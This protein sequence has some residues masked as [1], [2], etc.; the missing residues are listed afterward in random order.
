MAQNSKIEWTD[1]TWNPWMGCTKVS[2]GCKHCYAMTMMDHRYGKVKW[3]PQGERI[4]TAKAYWK[5]PLKWNET[6]FVQCEVCGLRQVFDQHGRCPGCQHPMVA[7]MQRVRQRVF[8]ASLADVFE[9]KADQ[10]EEMN[11]WRADLFTMIEQTPNLD[12][13]LLTK[14]PENVRAMCPSLPE[15]VWIG[16]SV[17][18][19]RMAEERIPALV[20]IPAKIHFLSVEPMLE[21]IDLDLRGKHY[22]ID[23]PTYSEDVSWVICGGESGPDAR[24][25]N[26]EWARSLRDQCQ[27]AGVPFFFKQWGEWAPRSHVQVL[28]LNGKEKTFKKKP[29]PFGDEMM[30]PVGKHL[31]GNVLDGQE[32][33]EFPR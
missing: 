26:P 33:M 10:L 30:L 24:P 8:C 22:G 20:R 32:I 12:W 19:Q 4:R 25:M 2:D 31:S 17:E 21:K 3:G 9:H 29:V 14:R 1:H 15:N 13:L 5:K 16:T 18:N 7:T 28:G 23:Y 11:Q 6:L 27:E